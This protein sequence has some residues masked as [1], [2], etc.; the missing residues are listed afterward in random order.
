VCQR[1]NI[2]VREGVL[3]GGI[4]IYKCGRHEFGAWVPGGIG[5]LRRWKAQTYVPAICWHSA[6]WCVLQHGKGRVVRG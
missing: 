2:T 4:E 5:P 3:G 1:H 6:N